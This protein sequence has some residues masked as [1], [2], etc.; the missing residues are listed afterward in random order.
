MTGPLTLA[1]IPT[2]SLQAAP[3][4]YVDSQIATALPKVGGTLTG[5][6]FLASDPTSSA[7]AATKNYVD[8]QV[9]TSSAYYWWYRNRTS[10]A[11]GHSDERY[12]GHSKAVR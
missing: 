4:T 10:H 8:N 12:A 11:S 1:A 2:A 9:A 5:A 3:K 6:L 7:Q